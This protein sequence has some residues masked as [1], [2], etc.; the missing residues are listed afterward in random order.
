M[1]IDGDYYGHKYAIGIEGRYL[2]GVGFR[3]AKK[4]EIWDFSGLSEV[5]I[6]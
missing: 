5:L 6:C 1:V 4:T 2:L 3:V